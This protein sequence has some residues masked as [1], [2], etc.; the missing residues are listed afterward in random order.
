MGE[1]AKNNEVAEE[2]EVSFHRF[3]RDMCGKNLQIF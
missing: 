2:E 3:C 1:V